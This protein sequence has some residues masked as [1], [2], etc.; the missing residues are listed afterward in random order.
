MAHETEDLLVDVAQV[1]AVHLVVDASTV[2]DAL[3]L[4]RLVLVRHRRQGQVVGQRHHGALGAHIP[5]LGK[6]RQRM[7]GRE[8]KE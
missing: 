7:S 1:P 2:E 5:D 3:G 6:G 8:G 4:V